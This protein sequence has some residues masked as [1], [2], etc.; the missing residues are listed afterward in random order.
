MEPRPDWH[1]YFVNIAFAVA[2]RSVCTRRR[3]G[4]VLVRDNR[5]ISTGYN[6]APVGEPECAEAC[7]RGQLSYRELPTGASYD[8]GPGKCIAIHA[9]TNAL[10][11]A[12][13]DLA[14]G[15]ILYCTHDPCP[16]C[17]KLIREMGIASVITP[18]DVRAMQFLTEGFR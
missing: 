14:R 11:H 1:E 13:A 8:S 2:K 15:A 4:A 9:E 12:G 6:G 17:R 5:V 10:V 16:E 18:I 3:V 7:P